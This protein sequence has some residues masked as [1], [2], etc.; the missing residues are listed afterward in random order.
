MYL[1]SKYIKWH[2]SFSFGFPHPASH[3]H[4]LFDSLQAKS[5]LGISPV[6]LKKKKK[7]NKQMYSSASPREFGVIKWAAALQEVRLCMFSWCRNE[8]LSR[9]VDIVL[10][11]VKVRRTR[12]GRAMTMVSKWRACCWKV[13]CSIRLPLFPNYGSGNWGPARSPA[14]GESMS[15]NVV[16][17]LGDTL[18]LVKSN[19]PH[20][21]RATLTR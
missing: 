7:S 8:S 14:L 15:R 5:D 13:N 17:M 2:L 20:I 4:T 19:K 3:T 9:W 11:P 10:Y 16:S 12:G 18:Q 6:P 21:H 1:K